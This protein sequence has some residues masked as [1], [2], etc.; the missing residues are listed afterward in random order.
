MRGKVTSAVLPFERGVWA[1]STIP[2]IRIFG[3]APTSFALFQDVVASA[4]IEGTAL[5][6]HKKAFYARLYSGAV[7]CIHPLS[8]LFYGF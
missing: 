7:H 3:R 2:S 5:V 1:S 6:C 4:A 8:W